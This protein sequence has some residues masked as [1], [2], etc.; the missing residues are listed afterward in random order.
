ML[1]ILLKV[2]KLDRYDIE[3]AI[4]AYYVFISE[5]CVVC[6]NMGEDKMA[7]K[8]VCLHSL[9]LNES[10]GILRNYLIA[11]IAKDYSLMLIFRPRDGGNLGP[12]SKFCVP[13][14]N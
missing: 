9:P 4:Q 6:R 13:R 12:P 1:A 11:A 8:C 2:Q 5:P 14:I 3:G 7:G 10:M